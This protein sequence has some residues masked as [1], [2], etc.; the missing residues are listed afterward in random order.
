M[1]APP[2]RIPRAPIGMFR[3]IAR[4]FS[5]VTAAQFIGAGIAF[6]W[7]AYAARQLGPPQFGTFLLIV[8]YVRVV[9]VTI[10]AGVGPITF[11][12]LARRR[13][14]P[15]SL[16]EDI[17]SMRL[18]LGL[19]GY[20]GLIATLFALHEDLN[21]LALVAIS[22]VTLLLD[23]FSETYAAY[24]MARE[25]AALPSIY[26]VASIAVSSAVGAGFLYAGYGLV[27][28]VVLEAVC[29]FVMT[30]IWTAV[31]RSRNFRFSI[32]VRPAEWRRLLALIIPFAPIHLSNQLNRAL[33]VILL[34]R[35]SG[36]I[37]MQE[38]VG[39]YGPAQ[40]VTNTAVTL[41]MT[42]RRVMIPPVTARLSKGF[43][44]TRELDLA[45]K[46]VMAVFAL[47]LLVGSSFLA[48]ELISL[49]FGARYE[50]SAM[51]LVILGWAGALQVA[52]LVPE[53][54]L[55]A[56]PKHRLQ[57][58]VAGAFMS[59][60][61]NAAVC[62]LLIGS[63]GFL[64]AAIGAVVGRIVYLIYVVHYCRRQVGGQVLRLRTFGDCTLLLAAAFGL[65][66]LTFKLIGN[67]WI[68][69]V[70]AILLTL[71]LMAGFVLYLRPQ[72]VACQQQA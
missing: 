39:Y 55:F 72:L 18:V 31:F 23:P 6:L 29:S 67:A 5:I 51:A 66:D 46:V 63:H 68:A 34:G 17:I 32:R 13:D 70:A 16:F 44:V 9:S 40:S 45:V 49:L 22:A 10:N 14:D 47:P 12:E 59:V 4:N 21:L 50:P 71:P 26:T 60:L 20:V 61:A 65:W 36:P 7:V 54:F 15:L 48:P 56:H 41:V 19:A 28:V 11:R 37:P 3:V 35:L 42:L 24:Y 30:V 43:T 62:V 58:Y 69:G 57:D 33:N 27:A 1:P 2:A 64:G 52:A 53:T 25:R 38:S 8:A